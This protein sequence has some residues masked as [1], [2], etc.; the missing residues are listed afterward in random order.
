MFGRRWNKADVLCLQKVILH[1]YDV[2]VLMCTAHN[3]SVEL[4]VLYP[5]RG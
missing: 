4:D 5:I 2:G 3:I 1:F